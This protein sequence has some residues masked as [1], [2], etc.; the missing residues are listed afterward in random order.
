MKDKL[1]K[2]QL[3]RFLVK[4]LNYTPDGFSTGKIDKGMF[5]LYEEIDIISFP[6]FNVFMG[7][8]V[9]VRD[10]EVATIIRYVGRPLS[11]TRDPKWFKYDVYEILVGNSLCQVFRQNIEP[12]FD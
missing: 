12:I 4:N 9:P 7:N 2:G 11:I 8:S 6:S 5:I 1:K 3:I 10:G